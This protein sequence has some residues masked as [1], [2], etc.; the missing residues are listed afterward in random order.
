MI[1]GVITWGVYSTFKEKRFT[2]PFLTLVHVICTFGLICVFPQFFMR[3]SQGELIKF[4]INLLYS[5]F[6]SSCFQV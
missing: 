3:F 4:D 5:Y 2:L 6:F 1:G